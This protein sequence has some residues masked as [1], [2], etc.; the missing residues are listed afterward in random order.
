MNDNILLDVLDAI[1]IAETLEYMLE[2]LTA[3]DLAVLN[4]D[5]TY[6]LDDLRKDVARLTNKL[7]TAKGPTSLLAAVARVNEVSEGDGADGGQP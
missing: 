1:E 7:L 5:N 3:H 6:G 2:R 4:K